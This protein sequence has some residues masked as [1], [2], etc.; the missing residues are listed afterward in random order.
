LERIVV[1]KCGDKNVLRKSDLWDDEIDGR[2]SKSSHE[3]P[4]LFASGRFLLAM[5]ACGFFIL[6]L[7]FALLL[8]RDMADELEFHN[9]LWAVNRRAQSLGGGV[10]NGRRAFRR[11]VGAWFHGK[12]ITDRAMPEIVSIIR[13]CQSRGLGGAHLSLDISRTSISDDGIKLLHSVPGLDSVSIRDTNA[14]NDGV[15]SLQRVLP[16][17]HVDAW[18]IDTAPSAETGGERDGI[19]HK[20]GRAK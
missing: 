13:D 5:G 3:H 6:F 20:L 4:I 8:G 17:T 1:E 16:R 18:P 14:T 9:N 12:E 15:V 7:L 11:H 19:A 10:S 2:S